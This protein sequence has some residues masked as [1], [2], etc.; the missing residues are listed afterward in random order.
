MTHLEMLE[1]IG[2]KAPKECPSVSVEFYR[3]A[4]DNKR[5]RVVT[6][7]YPVD[8]LGATAAEAIEAAYKKLF[9]PIPESVGEGEEKWRWVEGAW[10]SVS[11]H[12]VAHT[13]I[14]SLLGERAYYFS[15]HEIF[16][17]F[18]CNKSGKEKKRKAIPHH[19]ISA[20]M[21]GLLKLIE[22][23]PELKPPTED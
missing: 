4:D 1:K 21:R 12:A 23:N 19:L 17:P 18:G 11:C 8:G 3:G 2:E 7:G 14:N 6:D 5:W 10:E 15:D 13:F 9:P 16:Q 22:I 20:A